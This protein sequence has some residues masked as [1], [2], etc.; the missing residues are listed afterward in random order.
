MVEFQK[1][2]K[3]PPLTAYIT[4]PEGEGPFPAVII[5]MH[6]PGADKSQQKVA[7]D[8]K[9]AG[10]IGVLHDSYRKDT[11]KDSYTDETIFED[12]EYTLGYIK[13]NITQLDRTKIGILGFCMGGRHVY[14][15]AAKYSELKTAVSYYGF[16]GQGTNELNTPLKQVK[17]MNIPVLGIFGRQDHL[18]PFS[19]VENF[20]ELLLE[21]SPKNK[22]LIFDDAGHGFLNPYSEKRYNEKSATKAWESTISFFKSNFD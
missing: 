1:L 22:I 6:R 13:D 19:D 16:P 4:I 9:K 8:L 21:K 5:F 12:F 20:K 15:A 14:L 17:N 2:R 3:N 18:F 11:I 10:F 7:N